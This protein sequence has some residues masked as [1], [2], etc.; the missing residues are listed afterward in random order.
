M[1]RPTAPPGA[2][3]RSPQPFKMKRWED[4]AWGDRLAALNQAHKRVRKAADEIIKNWH[5]PL[6]RHRQD[7]A[8]TDLDQFET[9][10]D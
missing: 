10:G 5:P 7:E 9:W 1:Y 8:Y 3:S 2:A 6:T 4:M